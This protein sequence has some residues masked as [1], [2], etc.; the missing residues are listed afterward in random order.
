MQRNSIAVAQHTPTYEQPQSTLDNRELKQSIVDSAEI[1]D[2]YNQLMGKY[3]SPY[4]KL[5][6]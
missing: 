5:T 1:T 4:P 6:D 2:R 3:V